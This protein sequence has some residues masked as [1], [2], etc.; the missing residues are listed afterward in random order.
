MTTN[1][2]DWTGDRVSLTFTDTT[3][4]VRC[5]NPAQ[6]L[7]D[8]QMETELLSVLDQLDGW[9]AGRVVIITGRDPGMFIRHYNVAVLHQRALAMQAAGKRFSI[10]RPVPPAGIHRFIER[11]GRS[12]LVFIA[13]INGIAMGGGFELALGCDIRVVQDGDFE[14]GLPELNL[15][16]LP[17]AGGT[18]QMSRLLGESRAMQL[19][20]TASVL[21]PS[22]MVAWGLA[23]ASVPDALAHAVDMAGRIAAVPARACANIKQLVR[24]AS[25]WSVAEGEAAE[26]TLFCDCMVDPA[27]LP[28]MQAVGS[29]ERSISSP[30][31]QAGGTLAR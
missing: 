14:L 26:R 18:Q 23:A 16:L 4:V 31:A 27:A 17:G 20:L 12:P 11:V 5:F 22:Q 8:A 19:L 24:G 13:A 15:G 10:E 21:E 3:A 1:P 30:P 6:G 25:R 29:G 28:L 9:T 2:A 7:M